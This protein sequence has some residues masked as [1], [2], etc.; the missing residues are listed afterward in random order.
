MMPYA[1]TLLFDDAAA[2]RVRTIWHALA[3]QTGADDAIRLG[4]PPHMTLAVLPDTA[5][6][7]D[8]EEAAFRVAGEWA[9][10]PI[11]LA[12]LGVFP[13]APSVV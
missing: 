3:E 12:G 2:A 8:V 11:T 13:G 9:D 6:V 10:F 1:V 5:P 7:S 4:Y